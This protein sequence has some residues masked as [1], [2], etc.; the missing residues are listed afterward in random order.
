MPID[1]LTRELDEALRQPT[2]SG[3]QEAIVHVLAR[4]IRQVAALQNRVAEL[5]QRATVSEEGVVPTRM[6]S[7]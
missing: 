2:E 3:R 1:I 5:E 7:A 6:R 4:A